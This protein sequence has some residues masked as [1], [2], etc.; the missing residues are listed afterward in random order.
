MTRLKML[1][2]FD[3]EFLVLRVL[4]SDEFGPEFPN[5]PNLTTSEL[6]KREEVSKF[7]QEFRKEELVDLDL[8]FFWKLFEH[9]TILLIIDSKSEITIVR[10]S[11]FKVLL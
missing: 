8:D 11:V 9:F 7:E 2:Y 3:H 10:P 6:E 1:H 5:V 4:P